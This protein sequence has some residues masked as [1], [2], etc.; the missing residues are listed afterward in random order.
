VKAVSSRN[1]HPPASAAANT[2]GLNEDNSLEAKQEVLR[3]TLEVSRMKDKLVAGRKETALALAKLD[4]T[5]KMSKMDLKACEKTKA[6]SKAVATKAKETAMNHAQVVHERSALEREW[7]MC[8]KKDCISGRRFRSAELVKAIGLEKAVTEKKLESAQV[9]VKK[10][11]SEK[12][13]LT[14]SIHTKDAELASSSTKLKYS[15]GEL[16]GVTIKPLAAR[17]DLQ[18]KVERATKK[19]MCV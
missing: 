15:V 19:L 2:A 5:A 17:N 14:A 11:H 4:A 6:D 12:T 16:K 8:S 1:D 10:L 18:L 9:Q 13:E 7:K 3:L